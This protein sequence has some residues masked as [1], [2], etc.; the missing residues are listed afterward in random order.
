[1]RDMTIE[2]YNGFTNH[3]VN[4]KGDVI[5]IS[6]FWFVIDVQERGMEIG[7]PDISAEKAS[8]VLTDVNKY[9]DA[10]IGINWEVLDFH[11]SE[12]CGKE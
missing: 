11:I 7:Y 8:K 3:I 2:E 9:H 1:M 4:K 12:N 5:G 6:S 10:T